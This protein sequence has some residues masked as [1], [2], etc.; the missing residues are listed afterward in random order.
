M[1]AIL[2]FVQFL[3]RNG[4][5]LLIWIIVAY[6]VLSWLMAFNVVNLRHP[7]VYRIS[8]VLEGVVTPVL[9]PF[10]R[11]L[12]SFG[13]LDFSPIILFILIGG[14]QRYLIPPLFDWLRGLVGVAA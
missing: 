8:R 6:A 7:V 12:P 1:I 4:L 5:E 9:A 10:R 3:V 13:G 11:V 2:N 14:A